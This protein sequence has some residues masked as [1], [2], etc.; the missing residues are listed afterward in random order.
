MTLRGSPEKGKKKEGALPGST[1]R[2]SNKEHQGGVNSTP[3][4]GGGPA[5][6]GLLGCWA[7][8]ACTHCGKVPQ[9]ALRRFWSTHGKLYYRQGCLF[10]FLFFLLGGQEVS[11]ASADQSAPAT[12]WGP[13]GLMASPL[14]T[15]PSPP[16]PPSFHAKIGGHRQGQGTR[17]PGWAPWYGVLRT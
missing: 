7:R 10:F 8:A 6:A 13:L 15:P 16:H 17:G 9:L 2:V 11:I 3:A 12:S 5:F 4:W 14:P 1:T